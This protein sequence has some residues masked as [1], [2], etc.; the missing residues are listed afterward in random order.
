MTIAI[1]DIYQG[2]ILYRVVGVGVNRTVTKVAVS[3]IS[4]TWR[5]GRHT[6]TSLDLTHVD[7]EGEVHTQTVQSRDLWKVSKELRKAPPEWLPRA[8]GKEAKCL[9]FL[10]ECWTCGGRTADRRDRSRHKKR[11]L[12]PAARRW[13]RK[14]AQLRLPF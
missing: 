6:L 3:A 13:R 11:C 8:K 9:K 12:H 4:L 2:R 1:G 14:N 7:A 10:Y 5:H